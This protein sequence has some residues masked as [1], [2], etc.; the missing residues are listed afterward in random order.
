MIL[1]TS[2]L[3]RRAVLAGLASLAAAQPSFATN[4]ESPIARGILTNNPLALA[5]ESSP[6]GLPDVTLV[7]LNGERNISELKGR[8]LLMPLW[9][10]WCAPCMGEIPDFARLQQ[11]YGNSQFE[12]VPVLTGPRKQVTP[13]VIADMFAFL[14]ASVFEPLMENH[15]NDKLMSVMARRKDQ[16]TI[17]CNLLIAPNGRVVAREFGLER[18]DD[19]TSSAAQL[20]SSGKK[21]G[22]IARAEAG[23]SL[24]LWGKQAG[25]DFAAAMANGFL[26]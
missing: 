4:S 12:I 14:H 11:K 10:E 26:G 23:E 8:T 3:S 25:E 20:T 9:A 7:G 15:F 18:N 19:D 24:S 16:V 21:P 6:S 2:T 17:P 22:L 5:F 13:N 1:G